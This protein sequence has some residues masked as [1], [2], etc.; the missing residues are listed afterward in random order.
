MIEQSLQNNPN[1]QSA[2]ATL[3]SAKESVYAQEGKFFPLVQANFNPTYQRTSAVLAPVPASG[4][5]I[6]QLDTAQLTVAYTFDIW[7]LNRRTVESLE[8]LADV[9]RFQVEAAYLSLTANLVV[10]AITEASLRGQIDATVQIIAI[11]TKMRDTLQ[12]QLDA[13]LRQSQRSGGTGGGAGAGQGDAAAVAQGAGARA[14]PHRGAGRRLCEP[15]P[16]SD[17]QACGPAP[18]RRS[19]GQ[20]AVAADR[21]AP[22][23]ARG[24]GAIALGERANRRRHRQHSA[25]VHDQRRRRIH[26]YGAGASARAAESVLATG[27]QRHADG[28]RRRH[29]VSPASRRQ[30][31]LSGGGLD[32]PRHGDRRRAERRRHVARAAK[33]R[34]CVEGGVGLSNAP[35]R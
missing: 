29:A 32:L 7:G 19:A 21:A 31:Y 18:A 30:G 4:A 13:G 33:R 9:Q 17:I 22:G 15:W 35:P 24:R 26:E 1:L 34:R 6:F 23:R 20:P 16:G 27:R 14:R 11:N 3:R 5:S 28:V 12:R 25:V 2:L 8:A 10:A